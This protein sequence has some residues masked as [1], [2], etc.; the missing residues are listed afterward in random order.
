MTVA[1]LTAKISVIGEAA[2]VRA[3]Q[4]VGNSARSVGEAIRTAADATRLLEAAQASFATVTGVQAAMA[5]DS[6]VRGL[7]AYAKN[8]QELQA[9][10]GRLQEIAKLPGLGLKE[11]RAGV[12]Q[13]EAAGL[14]AQTAER[15]LMAFGNALAL[16]GK[17]K[18]ELDGVILALGQI[19]SK[20]SISAEEIN[21]IA[22]R[23]PQIRQVLVSAF[24]TAS[25]EAIQKMGI[26]ADAAIKRIISG[27]ERLPKATQSALTTFEN[28]QDA[29]EQAFLPIGRG[30]LDIF[31]SA[32]GG[33]M[34]LID[35]VANIGKQIGEVFT[36][37][38]KSGV[39]QDVLGNFLQLTGVQNFQQMM[40]GAIANILAYMAS[41][42]MFWNSA[43]HDMGEAFR[44]VKESMIYY[45]GE[46]YNWAA[47]KWNEL[48]DAFSSGVKDFGTAFVEFIQPILTGLKK[49]IAILTLGAV[50]LPGGELD[51]API[52]SAPTAGK[53][54]IETQTL[55]PPKISPMGPNFMLPNAVR[56]ANELARQYQ[57]AIM[58][59]LG[60]QGLPPGMI[61]GGAQGTAGAMGG[62]SIGG[63]LG[64]IADNTKTTADALTLRRETLGG[65]KMGALGVTAGELAVG[66]G[67]G[68]R[69]GDFFGGGNNGLIPAGTELER[70]V[71][72]IMRDE[73]RKNGTPGIMKRF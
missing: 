23:V 25:T 24:G 18:S 45:F 48:M 49:A 22:E 51:F 11:V 13:L 41:I 62:D 5:Y 4:R 8:A 12:L 21:Q 6:Q 64:K 60:P 46:A 44:F 20:G 50:Q 37:I 53:I 68:I 52:L 26:S 30:I 17:G 55:A 32:E 67:G 40:I 47:G 58:G 65:G 69:M 2:A 54:P 33:T 56:Y 38:G 1:E 28:L 9:Q 3:L 39:I 57:E 14:N 70:S 42:P 61:Y 35:L 27:L 16:V 29:L 73:A 43:V 31:S 19:A 36:A 15:A 59:N 72:R 34:R 63:I 71:R 10:L 66:G 7:A